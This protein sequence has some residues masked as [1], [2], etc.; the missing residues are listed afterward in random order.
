MIIAFVGLGEMGGVI[1]SSLS[2][3]GNELRI[4]DNS[5]AAIHRSIPAGCQPFESPAAA[6]REAEV[7]ITALPDEEDVRAVY[8][9]L[10]PE[11]KRGALLIDCSTTSPECARE[12]G[13]SAK[14]YGLRFADAPVTGSPDAA[15]SGALVF[16]V[17]C[18]AEDYAQVNNVLNPVANAVIHVGDIGAGQTGAICNSLALAI[19]MFASSE[20]VALAD[21]MGLEPEL[22]FKVLSAGSGR[23]G[24]LTDHCPVP[25]LLAD[26]PSNRDYFGGHTV[27]LL[28]K[29]LKLA[30]KAAAQSGI[31]LPLAERV[32]ALYSEAE[33]RGFGTRDLSCVYQMIRGRLA[34]GRPQ[35]SAQQSYTLPDPRAGS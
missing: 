21:A 2:H 34:G 24:A 32:R 1:A 25:G 20:A 8:R 11:T 26:A 6:A 4:F 16:V 10:M 28:L 7:V 22:F 31:N 35:R 18:S 17:G 5:G 23:N 27:S 33:A 14:Q 3:A 9:D 19:G 29:D 12:I 15:R 13:Q 30:E